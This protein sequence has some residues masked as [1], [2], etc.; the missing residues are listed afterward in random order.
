MSDLADKADESSETFLSAAL[1][2]RAKE[3]ELHHTGRC[4]GCSSILTG[5][6][7]YWCG[8]DCREDWERAEAMAKATHDK[9]RMQNDD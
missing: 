2:H 6:P 7:A 1:S 4:H 8:L 3:H 5:P 9:Q